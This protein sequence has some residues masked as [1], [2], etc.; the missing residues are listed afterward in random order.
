MDIGTVIDIGE[1]KPSALPLSV[2]EHVPEHAPPV[3]TPELVP[4]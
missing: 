3:E 2:P 1:I 4:A